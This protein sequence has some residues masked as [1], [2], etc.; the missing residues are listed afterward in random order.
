MLHHYMLDLNMIAYINFVERVLYNSPYNE[1]NLELIMKKYDVQKNHQNYVEFTTSKTLLAGETAS[2]E[3]VFLAED[4]K[5]Y[6]INKTE[7]LPNRSI[8]CLV[9]I[10]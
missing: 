6:T 9:I 7:M 1:K 4:G 3:P 5:F 10:P 2:G 8:A